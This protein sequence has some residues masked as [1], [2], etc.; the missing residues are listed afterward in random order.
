MDYAQ[1]SRDFLRGK[2]LVAEFPQSTTHALHS[3][4]RYLDAHNKVYEVGQ[5]YTDRLVIRSGTIEDDGV[6]VK[7]TEW[8][9]L[10]DVEL[11]HDD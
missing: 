5:T 3:I 7:W 2:R 1:W 4:K 6:S 11:F 8:Q 9:T 10:H